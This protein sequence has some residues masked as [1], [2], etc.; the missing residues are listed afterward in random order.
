LIES[1]FWT[2]DVVYSHHITVDHITVR[3]NRPGEPPPLDKGPSTDGINVDSSRFVLVQDCDVDCNDDCYSFKSGMNADG[4]RINR[5]CEYVLFRRNIARAGDGGITVGSDMSGGVRHVE[6][7]DFTCIGTK[8]GLRMKSARVRGGIVEDVTFRRF[9]L[10]NVPTAISFN[11]NWFPA[12]SYPVLP[13]DGT[14]IKPHWRIMA[15]PVPPEKAIPTFRNITLSDITATGSKT[16]LSINGLP[17]KPL[18][19]VTLT[20]IHIQSQ[21]AGTIQN[22][23]NWHIHNLTLTTQD[24][25][26]PRLLNCTNIPLPD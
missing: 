8:E 5:P 15:Q 2:I 24:A 26:K 13:T 9:T 6:A 23:T 16:A 1:P 21:T 10:T 7:T 19:N 12:F 18:D 20:N 22:A 4:L 17:E 3:N 14:P 25:S 11:L